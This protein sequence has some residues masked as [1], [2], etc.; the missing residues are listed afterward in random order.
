LGKGLLQL[1]WWAEPFRR[2]DMTAFC[3]RIKQLPGAKQSP[4]AKARCVA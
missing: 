4:L 2:L 3:P 1:H